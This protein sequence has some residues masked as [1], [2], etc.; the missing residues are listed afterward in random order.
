MLMLGSVYGMIQYYSTPE[1]HPEKDVVY[2]VATAYGLN[3]KHI[4][5]M[6][7][8]RWLYRFWYEKDGKR[9]Q[10]FHIMNDSTIKRGEQFYFMYTVEDGAQGELLINHPYP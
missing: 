5:Q 1:K 6:S 7:K 9:E 8:G 4:H 3:P 10:V 2:T